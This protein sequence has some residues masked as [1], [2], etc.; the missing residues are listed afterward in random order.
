MIQ[1]QGEKV[2]KRLS[3]LNRKTFLIYRPVYLDIISYL[4]YA[5]LLAT[6]T[7]YSTKT[8]SNLHGRNAAKLKP[9]G[10]LTLDSNDRPRPESGLLLTLV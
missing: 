1:F 9:K 7:I 2:N 10:A 5:W 8:I 3:T 6:T 4:Q